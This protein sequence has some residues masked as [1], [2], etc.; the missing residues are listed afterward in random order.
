MF[1]GYERPHPK[2]DFLALSTDG[3]S[4]L[5]YNS[6]HRPDSESDAEGSAKRGL[7]VFFVLFL[8][9]MSSLGLAWKKQWLTLPIKQ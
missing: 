2:D 7:V 6:N 4:P 1:F 8:L 9:I 3:G 5:D